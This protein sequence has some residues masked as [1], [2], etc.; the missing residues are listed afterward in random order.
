MTEELSRT[1]SRLVLSRRR[2]PRVFFN[3]ATDK[4][5]FLDEM[6]AETA[7]ARASPPAAPVG[8]PAP[9]DS[10]RKDDTRA[11]CPI[12]REI[13]TYVALNVAP[14]S[15]CLVLDG[16][17]ARTTKCILKHATDA[18][19][20]IPNH[21]PG[22]V[23]KL[24][25][26]AAK[27]DTVEVVHTSLYEHLLSTDDVYDVVYMDTCGFFTMH[28]EGDLKSAIEVCLDSG[29]F[30]PNGLFGV[31]MTLRTDGSVR[32]ADKHC[33]WWIMSHS[34]MYLVKEFRYGSMVT[35]F[36]RHGPYITSTGHRQ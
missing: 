35:M 9:G 1:I 31:T 21:S 4:K 36:F 29:T 25:R 28:T 14:S 16:G 19:V 22:T 5:S 7:P 24:Q 12:K 3:P 13:N 10:Y 32:H 6:A 2:R 18:K 26:F 15:N 17:K 34:G 30:A 8:R 23:I 27:H 11:V 33:A 20:T